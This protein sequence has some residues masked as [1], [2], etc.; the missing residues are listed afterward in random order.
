MVRIRVRHCTQLTGVSN[1]RV[2]SQSL[3]LEN[4]YPI[5][6]NSLLTNEI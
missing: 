2:H 5:Y 3:D 4:T 1:D 6:Y